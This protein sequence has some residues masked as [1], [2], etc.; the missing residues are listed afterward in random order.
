MRGAVFAVFFLLLTP[1]VS[2]GLSS[3][4]LLLIYGV[5]AAEVLFHE[6]C[7]SNYPV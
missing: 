6:I 5:L 4:Q 2:R 7:H 1:S 3:A